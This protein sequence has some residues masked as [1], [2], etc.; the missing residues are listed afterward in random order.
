MNGGV[1]LVD[2]R[3]VVICEGEY[4]QFHGERDAV[5]YAHV[6]AAA[7]GSPAEVVRLADGERMTV[8]HDEGGC[9]G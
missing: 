1:G 5:R 3:Y 6:V 9:C 4:E 2:D 7:F 8:H